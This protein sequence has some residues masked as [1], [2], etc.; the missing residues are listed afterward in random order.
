MTQIVAVRSAF[1]AYRYPQADITQAV[2]SLA[3]LAPAAG[4]AG[5]TGT[6]D[7]AGAAGAA[8][9]AARKQRA[10]L[11]RLHAN[12][13]VETRHTVFPLAE[14]GALGAAPNDRYIE[15]ATALGE[16][17]LRAALAL[18]LAASVLL[19]VAASP[20]RRWVAVAGL[21]CSV[22]LAVAGSRGRGKVPF[23]AA[24]GI[25]GVNAALFAGG[26]EALTATATAAPHLASALG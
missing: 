6:S 7:S 4:G 25:A 21:C 26:V 18:L 13:G 19:L 10:L 2:A 24:I 5:G 11:E 23:L 20:G 1:P 22:V 12:A 14:Y 15:E 17:A 16:R 8:G 9:S 3:G